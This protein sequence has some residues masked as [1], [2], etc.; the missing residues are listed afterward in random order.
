MFVQKFKQIMAWTTFLV[1][2]ANV[3][4]VSGESVHYMTEEYPPYNFKSDDGAITGI[5]I[6]LLGEMHKIMGVSDPKISLLPWVRGYR[7]AQQAGEMNVIFATT[8]TGARGPLFKWVG[9]ISNTK[10]VLFC[11]ANKKVSINNDA[12]LMK[13]TYSV[14]RDDIGQL[15]LTK[16]NVPKKAIQDVTKFPQMAQLVE[17]KR[18]DC[19]AYEANVSNYLIKKHGMDSK[20]FKETYTLIDAELHYAFNKSVDDATIS[21]HQMALDK[22]RGDSSLVESVFGKYGASME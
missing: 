3:P 13:Y 8:K 22:V 12:D 14:I 19:F 18:R 2:I 16:R 20:T 17:I 4:V 11:N 7:S 6:D 1:F 21:S 15:Q 9:P 5:S 10:V